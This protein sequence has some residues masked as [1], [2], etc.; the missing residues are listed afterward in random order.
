MLWKR[1][2][3][4]RKRE[5]SLQ[6][7]PMRVW[8]QGPPLALPSRFTSHRYRALILGWLVDATGD[9]KKDAVAALEAEFFHRKQLRVDAGEP[10]PRPGVRVPIKISSRVR[11][12]S[13]AD[14]EEDFVR[15]VLHPVL[16]IEDVYMT[17]G[18]SLS[19]FHFD[20][21]SSALVA[22]TREVYGVDISDIESEN[23]AEILERIAAGRVNK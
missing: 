12:D 9:T 23:I 14:L 18:S 19:N 17:D 1:I 22:K 16:G 11:L 21:D 2:L 3:S 7:Y 5:W 13:H 6:D 20:E 10:I 4:Y 8:D 15:R